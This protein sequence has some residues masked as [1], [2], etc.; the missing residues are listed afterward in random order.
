MMCLPIRKQICMGVGYMLSNME[1]MVGIVILI[2]IVGFIYNT[3]MD[4][5]SQNEERNKV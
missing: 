1:F 4:N 3:F 5:D 2:V